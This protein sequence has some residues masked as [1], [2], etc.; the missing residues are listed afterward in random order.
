MLL[1]SYWAQSSK[2]VKV[3][4]SQPLSVMCSTHPDFTTTDYIT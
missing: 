3:S 2:L 1:M 4:V